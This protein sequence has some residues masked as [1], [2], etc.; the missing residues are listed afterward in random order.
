MVMNGCSTDEDDKVTSSNAITGDW[1]GNQSGQ[2]TVD[3]ILTVPVGQTLTLAPGTV[4]NFN[5]FAKM[6][7]RGKLNAIGTRE[8][9]ILF[10]SSSA[11]PDRGF[12]E[13]V[14]FHPNSDTSFVKWAHF[15]WGGRFDLTTDTISTPSRVFKAMIAV[16][17]TN[18]VISNSIISKA[19]W[20]GIEVQNSGYARVTNCTFFRNAFNA[21]SVRLGGRIALY[22]NIVTSNDDAAFRIRRPGGGQFIG[23]YTCVWD[24][25][26]NPP[27]INE[28]GAPF[29][30][31]TGDFV[32]DPLLI[33]PEKN[34]FAIRAGSG[35]IDK[36]D[37]ALPFD[38]DNTRADCGAYYYHQSPNEL[39]GPRKGTLTAGVYVVKYNIWV[40]NGDTLILNPGVTIKF[41]GSYSLVVNGK[42]FA[43]GTA[44]NPIRFTSAK[45]NPARGDWKNI[46]F[47]GTATSNSELKFVTIEY[48]G[49]LIP[50][51]S[52][53][54]GA[55]SINNSI[56]NLEDVT[57]KNSLFVGLH[58]SNGAGGTVQRLMVDGF[59]TYGVKC[60]LNVVTS[61]QKVKIVNGLGTGLRIENNSTPMITNALIA[62][63]DV[64]GVEIDR[65]SR[66]T[67][68]FFTIADNVYQG[69]AISSNSIVG[70]TNSIIARNGLHALETRISSQV[71]HTNNLFWRNST[72][73]SNLVVNIENTRIRDLTLDATEQIADPQFI[74]GIPVNYD[75]GTNSPA[76][77]AATDGTNLGAYGGPGLF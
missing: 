61:I 62:G 30:Q 67:L 15:R 27:Y 31:M 44:S 70:L 5:R 39:F 51:S 28:L 14:I 38:S 74:G 52:T 26:T 76:R 33:D 63:N 13:G 35:A 11:T 6:E 2:F 12:W 37:P 77:N 41:D 48:A 45:S 72:N 75:L 4:L 68:N 16:D 53:A 59:G 22:N 71:N 8:N 43:V 50:N 23:G 19:G 46:Y 58:L 54:N 73:N 1:F 32:L 60:E 47:N 20:D 34:D 40:E 57:I 21:L 17:N 24:N 29:E 55:L 66:P 65:L 25:N 3:G 10:T 64:T 56:L 36:G 49:I 69:V 18:L 9:P 42:L 7:I